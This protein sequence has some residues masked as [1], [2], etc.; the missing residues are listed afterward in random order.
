[1]SFENAEELDA[2]TSTGICVSQAVLNPTL[3]IE[4][5]NPKPYTWITGLPQNFILS[6]LRQFLE[7]GILVWCV[8]L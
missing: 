4:S 7:A 5:P 1:M 6:K 3:I 8:R 2:G